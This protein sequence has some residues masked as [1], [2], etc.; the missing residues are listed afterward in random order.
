MKHADPDTREFTNHLE[1][2]LPVIDLP[3]LVEKLSANRQ[4]IARCHD[5]F[6]TDSVK[7]V[8]AI[9]KGM[10][11][12]DSKA[13]KKAVHGLR[14][15]LVTL[16]MRKPAGTAE[17]LES[18]FSGNNFHEATFALRLL[19]EEMNAATREISCFLA[20]GE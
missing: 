4:M 17:A 10:A 2:V 6:A 12:G 18:M 11:A 3:A 9:R 8:A 19:E 15:M 1:T 7:A 16:E 13:A 5:I 20:A 14:G